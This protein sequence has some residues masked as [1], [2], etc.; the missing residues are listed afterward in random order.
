[1]NLEYLQLIKTMNNKKIKDK[2]LLQ[3]IY[4]Q[5]IIPLIAHNL[6]L[7]KLIV[8]YVIIVNLKSRL[9]Q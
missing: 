6:T 3:V 4:Q 7:C 1:M 9:K 2:D 8:L 5:K